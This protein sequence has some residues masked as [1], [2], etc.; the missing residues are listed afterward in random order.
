MS[1]YTQEKMKKWLWFATLVLT[2]IAAPT[3]GLL[4]WLYVLHFANVLVISP[5]LNNL[6][7]LPGLSGSAKLSHK[8][9][10]SLTFWVIV[11]AAMMQSDNVL[12]SAALLSLPFITK[13]ISALNKKDVLAQYHSYRLLDLNNETEANFKK[14]LIDECETLNIAVPNVVYVDLFDKVEPANFDRF[15]K[16]AVS[17][18]P[19]SDSL[20]AEQLLIKAKALM[21]PSMYSVTKS[22][23]LLIVNSSVFENEIKLTNQ[24]IKAILAHEMGHFANMDNYQLML[25]N[26][27]RLMTTLLGLT[28]L[29]PEGIAL[30]GLAQVAYNKLKKSIETNADLYSAENGHARDLIFATHKLIE[31]KEKLNQQALEK[32][33][34]SSLNRIQEYYQACFKDHPEDKDRIAV[35]NAFVAEQKDDEHV[36]DIQKTKKPAREG[37]SPVRH[38]LNLS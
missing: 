28:S 14:M 34:Q 31:C 20:T 17:M 8:I 5:L 10:M 22:E 25:S 24:E 38:K 19:G 18:F 7:E 26:G 16:D 21:L 36:G 35:L 2:V 29:R 32:T 6:R 3:L 12:F 1:V 33:T 9:A 4:D 11:V 30:A 37:R 27:I 15:R 23:N 13:G